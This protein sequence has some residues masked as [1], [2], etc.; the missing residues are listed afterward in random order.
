MNLK[1]GVRFSLR[2]VDRLQAIRVRIC[3]VLGDNY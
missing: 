3:C 1:S 2:H